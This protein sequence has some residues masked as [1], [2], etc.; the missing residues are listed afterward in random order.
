MAYILSDQNS[1]P[2]RVSIFKGID[3]ASSLYSVK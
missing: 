3:K 2:I 1:I